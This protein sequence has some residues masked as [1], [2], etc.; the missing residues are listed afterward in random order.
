MTG[1]IEQK[2]AF[3][4]GQ[5]ANGKSVLVDVIARVLNSYAASAKIESLTGQSKRGGA[6]A[7]PDLIPLMGARMVRAS[8]PEEGERFK[9][10]MIKELTGGEAI[11]VRALH[12]DFVEV[13]PEFKLTISGNHKPEIR[14]TD[15]GIWRRVMLVPFDVQI[16]VEER[17]DFD[18]FVSDLMTEGPGILNWLISGLLEYM[19]VGLDVPV[20]VLAATDE[21][22]KDSDP[23]GAFLT[24]N[25]VVNGV[26]DFI[27]ASELI[28][29][30]KFWLI[31]QGDAPWGNRTVSNRLKDR[32]DRWRHP[33]SGMTFT[34][35]KQRVT[36]YRGIRLTDTFKKRF[37]ARPS[38]RSRPAGSYGEDDR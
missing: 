10:G 5:G 6:D 19:E 18:E 14:G 27:T 21:Y 8:E 36:G 30:F 28:E 4:Y 12:S 25:T 37:D 22:R 38:E 34:R 32:A 26:D 11:L 24:E 23:V 13:N 17:R 7:T 3:F 16:P 9:E 2:L 29:G 31:E 35:G 33:T 1:K 20:S 15:D